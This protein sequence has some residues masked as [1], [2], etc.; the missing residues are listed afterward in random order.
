MTRTSVVIV[1]FNSRAYLGP[2]LDALLPQLGPDDELIVVDNGSSD[3]SAELARA[4]CPAARVIGGPNDGYAGGNNR[5]AAASSGEVLVFLN[6]DT[7]VRPGAL[8]A[9]T[10]PL[11][12]AAEGPEGAEG[13][14]GR[15]PIGLTT[16]CLVHHDRPE[17]VNAC[18][19]TV[20]YS[21][22]TYCRGA[23]RPRAELAEDADVDAVSGAAF[24]MR[25]ELFWALGGFDERFFMYC[26]DT[27]LSLRARLAGYRCRYVAAAVVLHH[28]RPSYTPAKAFYLDRNRHLMLLK[29]LGGA[30]YARLLP[31]LLLAELVTWGFLLLK[32][33][34]FWG[35]KPR[36]YAWLWRHRRAIAAHRRASPARPAPER[37]LLAGLSYRLEFEQLAGGPLA[38]FAALVFHPAFRLARLPLARGCA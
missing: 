33:P 13:G 8:A 12:P 26:E 36:V 22:L 21:G 29:S 27:D 28:Y 16:A 32:G 9:L 35:V 4:R 38:L 2:C 11:L 24:A 37:A 5:G 3:G 31:G 34:R 7:V 6:P 23:N 30:A 10:A 17:V 18:G 15:Q 25:R 20:H 14:E 1:T 19:N